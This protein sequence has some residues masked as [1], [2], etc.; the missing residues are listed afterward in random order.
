MGSGDSC[1]IDLHPIQF[2]GGGGV[3]LSATSETATKTGILTLALIALDYP[4]I[5]TAAKTTTTAT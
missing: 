1:L 3:L 2:G 5:M 4:K